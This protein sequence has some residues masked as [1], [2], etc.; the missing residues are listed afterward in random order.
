MH[1]NTISNPQLVVIVLLKVTEKYPDFEFNQNGSVFSI[2][3]K[4]WL[5]EKVCGGVIEMN[6]DI[7]VDIKNHDEENIKLR[8]YMAEQ[9]TEVLSNNKKVTFNT[10]EK[11]K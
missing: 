8:N 3:R 9:F 1:V 2:K 10:V 5:G 6:G 4:G 7:T 11:I